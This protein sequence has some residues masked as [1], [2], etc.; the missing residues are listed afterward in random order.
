MDKS[1]GQNRIRTMK[2]KEGLL[3]VLL[4]LVKSSE[5]IAEETR[6]FFSE[7][8]VHFVSPSRDGSSS[9]LR[10]KGLLSS[11]RNVDERFIERNVLHICRSCLSNN[12]SL[13]PETDAADRS[14][15]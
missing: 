14:D 4:N 6:E 9:V 7:S 10:I 11:V 15:V 1:Q 2:I 13:L 3:K 8:Q 12:D 5:K